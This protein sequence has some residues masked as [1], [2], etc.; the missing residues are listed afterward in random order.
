MTNTRLIGG[1]LLIVGTA[2]GGGMLALPIAASQLGFWNSCL[3]LLVSWLIMTVGAFLILEVNLWLPANSNLISMAKLTLG[4]KGQIV[5]WIVYLLLLYSLI[6]AYIAG[7]G[8]FLQNLISKAGIH[9]PQWLASILFT[10]I[11]GSVVYHG[12]RSVDYVNRGLMFTKLGVYIL[13]IAMVLAFVSP[14]KLAGGEFKYVTTGITV[15]LTSFGFAT[16]VPSL[17]GYFHDD[18]K[19]LRLAILIGSLIPLVCYILWDLAIMG[20]IARDG[21]HGLISMIHSNHSTSDLANQLSTTLNKEIITAMTRIFT[22]I[23]LATSFLGV[24]LGLTDF[25]ADGL[26]KTKAGKDNLTVQALTFIP[27]LAIVL[28]DPRIFITA[29]SYAGIYCMILL[30]LLPALMAWQGRYRQQLQG[31]FQMI[32][33]KPLLVTLIAISFAVIIEGISQNF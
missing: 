30:V 29:L 21:G 2:I 23:C 15:M 6:A 18:V 31:K 25:I 28:V 4:R 26:K 5:A 20:V 14:A 7:G 27:P 11:L 12:I 19:K 33:G 9:I 10:L 24:S 16:I 3:L 22:S 8:D 17:R 13:L 1:I 32:G